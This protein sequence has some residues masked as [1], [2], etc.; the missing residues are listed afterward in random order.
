MVLLN[1]RS[2]LALLAAAATAPALPVRA[3]TGFPVTIAHAWGDTTITAEPRRI[4]TW[5][6]CNEDALIALGIVPVAMPFQSYGGGDNG[7]Q[8]WVEEALEA[9]GAEPP[10]LLDASGEPPFEQI[11]A[12]A[13]DLIIATFSGLTEEQYAILSQIAPTLGYQGDAWS[14]P[15]Q[16]VLLTIG[17]ATGREAEAEQVLADTE[18]WVADTVA[19][20]PELEG[21]SFA[22]IGDFDG[23]IAVYDAL[24]ARVKFL[25]DLGLALSPSVAA[26]SPGDG[27]FYFPLSYERFDA[28]ESDILVTYYETAA[29]AEAFFAQPYVTSLEQFRNG[30]FTALV[31]TEYVAAVSPPSVLSLRWGLESYL[32]R[33]AEAARNARAED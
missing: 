14:T 18:A 25:T 11:A 8:T 29:E 27:A 31:G 10:P 30:A 15:W 16:E 23:S 17:R 21:A 13:P 6:W 3:Q 9:M 2:T 20:Y 7:I 24:D 1:R 4:V 32:E 19:T 5:G 12:L 28:L 33:L 26:L 22:A